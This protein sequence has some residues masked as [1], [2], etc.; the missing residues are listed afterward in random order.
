MKWRLLNTIANEE[1]PGCRVASTCGSALPAGVSCKVSITFTPSGKNGRRAGL[2]IST[3]DPASPDA[4]G[5]H[6]IGTFVSFSPSIPTFGNVKVG[7]SSPQSVT[8]TNNGGAQLNFTGITIIGANAGD[9]SETNTCGTSIAA[10]ASCT[11]TVTFKPTAIG[12]RTA[13]LKISD[14]GGGTPQRVYL[15]GTG[16]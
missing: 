10:N 11:L 13:N 6:G 5:L 1:Q 8:L 3:P 7:T 12:A 16:T 2:A 15:R 4:V 14:D 9:F